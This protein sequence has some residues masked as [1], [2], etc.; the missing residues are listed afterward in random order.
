M[1]P[2]L[3][4]F[5][6]RDLI[7]RAATAH[8]DYLNADPFPHV[9]F[10]DFLPPEVIDS[11]AAELP[12]V[13]PLPSADMSPTT[14]AEREKT[15][16]VAPEFFGPHTTNLLYQL[17]S[18]VFLDFLQELTGIERL[19]ADT[20]LDGGGYHLTRRGGRLA[21]HTD[22]SHHRT[23]NLRRRL[24]LILYL[25]K[26][27]QEDYGGHLELWDKGLKAVR[28]RI[29]PVANRCV[30]FNTDRGSPHGQPE[31]LNCPPDRGRQSLALYFYDN[32]TE[33]VQPIGTRYMMRPSEMNPLKRYAKALL[34]R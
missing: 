11:V 33:V 22:F 6:S 5:D 31:P 21:I 3:F 28:R 2:P 13:P 9:V 1:S 23:A 10:D 20:R 17:N 30:I 29:L 19:I 16:N 34:R 7:S 14:V 8:P 27:W 4:R 26:D 15:A 12:P 32:P 25:N 18:S 24:N